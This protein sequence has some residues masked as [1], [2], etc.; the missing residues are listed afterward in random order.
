MKLHDEGSKIYLELSQEKNGIRLFDA[1]SNKTQMFREVHD[2]IWYSIDTLRLSSFEK[3]TE[4]GLS[5][6]SR[7]FNPSVEISRSLLNTI[8]RE[9][10]NRIYYDHVFMKLLTFFRSDVTD[11]NL[12]ATNFSIHL[13]LL[14]LLKKHMGV[15]MTMN[16]VQA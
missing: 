1:Q 5:D 6:L 2:A 16:P 10:T 13:E 4:Q 15:K 11:V 8:K 9:K 12:A 3:L 7:H 14:H